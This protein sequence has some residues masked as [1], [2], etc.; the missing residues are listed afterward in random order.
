MDKRLD[1][2]LARAQARE[3]FFAA[4]WQAARALLRHAIVGAD[5]IRFGSGHVCHDGRCG[6]TPGTRCLHEMAFSIY[7]GDV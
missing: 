4:S 6:C 7:A 2:A 3:P 1:E 5:L